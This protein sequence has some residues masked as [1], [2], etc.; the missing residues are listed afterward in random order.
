MSRFGTTY[1]LAYRLTSFNQLCYLIN[2]KF[3]FICCKFTKILSPSNTYF[4]WEQK[5]TA[6][7]MLSI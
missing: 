4:E 2:S 1:L 6:S 5:L 3:I 7:S